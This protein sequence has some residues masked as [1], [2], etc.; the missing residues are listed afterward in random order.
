[1]GFE[2]S[3]GSDYGRLHICED[4]LKQQGEHQ[5]PENSENHTMGIDNCAQM[6][7]S[8]PQI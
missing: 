4:M 1:M 7:Q 5:S 6:D 3:E 2:I 8:K